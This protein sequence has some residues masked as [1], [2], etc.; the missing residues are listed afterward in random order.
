MYNRQSGMIQAML[1]YGAQFKTCPKCDNHTP[2]YPDCLFG[3]SNSTSCQHCAEGLQLLEGQAVISESHYLK[4]DDPVELQS[5]KINWD[6]GIAA[7]V[8]MWPELNPYN[9]NGLDNGQSADEPK[10]ERLGLLKRLFRKR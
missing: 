1:K 3:S 8:E 4:K 2:V 6:L 10:K 7:G 5:R 9:Q